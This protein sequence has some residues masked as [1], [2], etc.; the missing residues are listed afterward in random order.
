MAAALV[1]AGAP[2]VS[3]S[4]QPNIVGGEPAAEPYPFMTSLSDAEGHFCGA[5]LIRSDWLVTAAH[6]VDGVPADTLTARVGSADRAEGGEVAQPAEV[7]VHPSYTSPGS[8]GDVALVRLAQPVQA[9]PVDIAAAAEPGT[10][11]RLLGWG[12]TCAPEG[13]GD[14]SPRTLQQLDTR[15]VADE[16]C[17]AGFDGRSEVCTGNP[18]GAGACYGDS[19]GPQIVRDGDRWRLVGMSSRSGN[20]D[21]VC[22]SAPSI[23]TSAPAH[24]TWIDETIAAQAPT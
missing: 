4:V 13:C 7:V 10:E 6:C 5:S 8:T 12:R 14:E 11:T 18:E 2:A 3:A 24:Q 16:R 9:E 23:Y 1:V 22:G 15:V 19:G 20:N 17:A 21:P